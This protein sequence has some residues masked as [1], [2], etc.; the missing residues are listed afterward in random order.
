MP[1]TLI[2][3]D[4]QDKDWLDREARLRGLPM[5]ELV[6]QAVHAYRERQESL[7]Q[8]SLQAALARTAGIWK[9]GDGLAHQHRMRKEWDCRS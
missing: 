5:T 7:E 9:S 1:R 6:R 8:P 4:A 3:L 2:S